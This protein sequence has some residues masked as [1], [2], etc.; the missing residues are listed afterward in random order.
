MSKVTKA[1]DEL[2]LCTC[3]EDTCLTCT[4]KDLLRLSFEIDTLST[5]PLPTQASLAPALSMPNCAI[6]PPPPS[7]ESSATTARMTGST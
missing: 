6:L 2:K 3:L 5:V 1:V 7:Q 4:M